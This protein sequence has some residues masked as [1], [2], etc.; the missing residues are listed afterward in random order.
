MLTKS[1][2]TKKRYLYGIPPELLEILYPH[3]KNFKIHLMLTTHPPG[4]ACLVSNQ[5]FDG[6]PSLSYISFQDFLIFHNKTSSEFIHSTD[7]SFTNAQENIVRESIKQ[8]AIVSKIQTKLKTSPVYPDKI[9]M[10]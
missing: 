5:R 3:F 2:L 1:A 4:K 10:F 9:H 8:R 7:I 6:T